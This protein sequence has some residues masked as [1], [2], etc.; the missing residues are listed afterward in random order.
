[1]V[2]YIQTKKALFMNNVYNL[3]LKNFFKKNE[4]FNNKSF[5]INANDDILLD[6][7]DERKTSLG[8]YFKLYLSKVSNDLKIRLLLYSWCNKT[9]TYVAL[10]KSIWSEKG[11]GS[12]K[13]ISKIEND[14]KK[15]VGNFLSVFKQIKYYWQ[16]KEI[17]H[18]LEN[19]IFSFHYKLLN[20]FSREFLEKFL[21]EKFDIY[22]ILNVVLL[23]NKIDRQNISQIFLPNYSGGF[24]I[25][26][27]EISVDLDDS[28][29]A[30]I[31]D[32]SGV[33]TTERFFEIIEK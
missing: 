21:L 7:N 10:N 6:K 31:E 8:I 33:I 12:G 27:I 18:K 17:I 24:Y 9:Q 4:K 22:S 25:N 32:D 29:F 2:S 26:G 1:M 28:D 3:V 5:L 16:L 30:I 15:I 20:T 11:F 19:A 13:Y 14:Y 23:K